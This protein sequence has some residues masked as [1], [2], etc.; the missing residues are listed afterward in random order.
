MSS[1]G[2]LEE[3][4][5][6]CVELEVVDLRGVRVVNERSLFVLAEYCTRLKELFV[7]GCPLVTSESLIKL[8]HVIT[9]ITPSLKAARNNKTSMKIPG[10]I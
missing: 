4:F 3:V 5:R 1:E 9:D 7:E 6:K 10:Q 2:N 8:Q